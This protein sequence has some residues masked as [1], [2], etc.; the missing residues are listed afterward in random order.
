MH[1]LF[2]I[3]C[4]AVLITSC[5]VKKNAVNTSQ[6]TN[7]ATKSELVQRHYANPTDFK[8]ANIRTTVKFKDD[9][10]DQSANAEIRIQKDSKILIVV[11]YI[12]ITFA[13]VYITPDRVSYY[14]VYNSQY[15][16][17]DY[18]LLSNLIGVDLDYTKVQNI[19][20]GKSIYDLNNTT[21][22]TTLENNLQKIKFKTEDGIQNESYFEGA[23]YLLMKTILNQPNLDRK[24]SL[25]YNKYNDNNGTYLPSEIKIL[26]QQEQ[27]VAI[28]IK[29]N[30]V[31][32]NDNVSFKYEIPQGFKQITIQE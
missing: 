8:T 3:A 20:L 15:F 5:S 10:N 6:V 29:Y 7:K 16:D 32:F 23:N 27:E 19:F 22:V 24:L 30:S 17:G 31:S 13:K 14:D 9:K 18:S 4:M 21:F 11:R 12:G 1:K 26:A 2:I 25:D 28:D